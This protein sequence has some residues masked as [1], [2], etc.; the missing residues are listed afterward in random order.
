MIEYKVEWCGIPV[1]KIKEYGTS[2]TCSKCNEIGKRWT[3]GHFKCNN[4]GR[5]SFN[6]DYNGALNILKR[7][8]SYMDITG[9]VSEPTQNRT[10]ANW[11]R[12]PF[13]WVVVHIGIDSMKITVKILPENS[14]K[15]VDLKSGSKVYDVLKKINLRPDALIVLKGNTPTF[16]K[17][18]PITP[19][20]NIVQAARKYL[21][22]W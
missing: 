19:S 5:I 21:A 12:K 22:G 18:N 9:L 14:I 6:A 3:Q 7:V 15:E 10:R 11:V 4:C 17:T 20:K 8:M 2:K 1:I 16:F 13:K